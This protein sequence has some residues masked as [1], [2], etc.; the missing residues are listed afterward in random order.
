MVISPD[1]ARVCK[2]EVK[3]SSVTSAAHAPPAEFYFRIESFRL[4]IQSIYIL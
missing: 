3:N 2:E 4:I 1:D